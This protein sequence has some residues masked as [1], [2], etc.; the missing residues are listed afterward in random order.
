M[1]KDTV[2]FVSELSKELEKQF[3]G[4]IEGTL[5]GL[6]SKEIFMAGVNAVGLAVSITALVK[7]LKDL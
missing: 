6:T 5:D 4:Q 7:E 2:K 3:D 1:N